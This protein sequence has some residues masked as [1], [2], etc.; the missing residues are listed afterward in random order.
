MSLTF[1][2]RLV[3]KGVT[4]VPLSAVASFVAALYTE[5]TSLTQIAAML[6]G[7]AT[8]VVIHVVLEAWAVARGYVDFRKAL[9]R[10]VVTKIFLQLIP[11]IEVFV[12][13]IANSLIAPLDLSDFTAGYL[14]TV[15]VGLGLSIIVFVITSLYWYGARK[16][17]GRAPVAAGS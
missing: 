13:Y 2:R 4:L 9:Y 3:L 1:D 5:H 8:F 11:A 7:I 10:A 6:C 12:G 16:L 15:T 17:R 14:M